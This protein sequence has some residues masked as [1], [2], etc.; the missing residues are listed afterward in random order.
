[1]KKVRYLAGAAGLVPAALGLAALPAAAHAAT[2]TSSTASTG[3]SVS[4]HHVR[5]ATQDTSCDGKTYE[6]IPASGGTVRGH[7]WNTLGSSVCVGTIVMSMYFSHTHCKNAHAFVT[8]NGFETEWSRTYQV[9]GTKGE[10]AHTSFGVHQW[11][12]YGDLI[13]LASQY[14][15]FALVSVSKSK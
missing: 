8:S 11:F 6:T 4:L 5:A 12:P 14:G 13:Y 15:G 1:M 3:K 10:W 7:F 9:C 2:S